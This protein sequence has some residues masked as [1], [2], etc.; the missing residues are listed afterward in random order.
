MNSL[1]K[2]RVLRISHSSSL[3]RMRLSYSACFMRL[4]LR[5]IEFGG[6]WEYSLIF[7]Q[8]T[9]SSSASLKTRETR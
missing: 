9:E 7:G 2:Y 6:N 5:R 3:A 4:L 8:I 1:S